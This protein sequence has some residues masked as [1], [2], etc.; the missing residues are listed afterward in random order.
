MAV[1]FPLTVT[2]SCRTRTCFPFTRCS[3]TDSGT[4]CSLIYLLRVKFP[5]CTSIILYLTVNYNR[6]PEK[7]T[8]SCLLRPEN[9]FPHDQVA[10]KVRQDGQYPRDRVGGIQ[11]E[12]RMLCAKDRK[13]PDD[14]EHTCAMTKRTSETRCSTLAAAS[15]K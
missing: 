3:F 14:T 15:T 8:L 2:R 13:N 10:H 12:Q 5:H 9:L 1:H 11:D 6:F 7:N 4:D